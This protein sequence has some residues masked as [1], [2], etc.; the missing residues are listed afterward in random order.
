[1]ND[2][3]QDHGRNR[4][5]DV[6]SPDPQMAR[7]RHMIASWAVL[8][9]LAGLFGPAGSIEAT[10]QSTATSSGQD[11]E[12]D[13][14]EALARDGIVLFRHAS[15]PGIGD[16]S[17]FRLDDCST[18]RNLDDTGRAQA[19]RIGERLKAKGV[20][21]GAV[22][23][24]Q[25]CRTRETARLMDLGPVRDEPAFNSF[26]ADRSG[27]PAQT[28]RAS[29]LLRAWRGPGALIVVTH[30]VNVSALTGGFVG[31]GEG[32][33][34]RVTDPGQGGGPTGLGVV[35]RIFDADSRPRR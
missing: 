25:W 15:A 2:P 28:T 9:G 18:Q 34:M 11:G 22:W 21:V 14:W 29:E 13:A 19:R 1:M 30:Q 4:R 17:N 26:F 12:G 24:S 23:T 8:G 7:R 20:P 32:V 10:A 35:G 16:P 31:S 27:E 3:Y 6:V 5:A 33:V